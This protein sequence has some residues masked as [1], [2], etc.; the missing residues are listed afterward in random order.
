MSVSTVLPLAPLRLFPL[1]RPA[2][3]CLSQ[4]RCPVISSASARSSTA[5]V[6]CD[7]KP[8]MAE[9]LHAPGLRL[10]QQLISQLLIDQ[11]PASPRA[12]IRFAGHR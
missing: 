10:A 1:P 4:P 6:T 12:A 7:N 2:G 3:S 8:V 5:L 11:R 9:Q